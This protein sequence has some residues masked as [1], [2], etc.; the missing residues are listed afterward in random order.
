M[1]EDIKKTFYKKAHHLTKERWKFVEGFGNFYMVSNMGRVMRNDTTRGRKSRGIKPRIFMKIN[2]SAGR[3][4][5]RVKLT[6]RN[7]KY[8]FFDLKVLVAN[9]WLKPRDRS[10]YVRCRNGNRFDCRVANIE[11]IR[12]KLY[13]QARL[14]VEQ[15]KEIKQEI[16]LNNRHGLKRLL[17]KKFGISPSTITQISKGRKWKEVTI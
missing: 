17:A 4:N 1:F 3:Y 12:P 9:H 11:E 10:K 13:L 8:R 15:V 7:G 6:D 14:S 5:P 16:L 2:T